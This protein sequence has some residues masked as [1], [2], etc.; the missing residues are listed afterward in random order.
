MSEECGVKRPRYDGSVL[1][2]DLLVG[3]KSDDK[4]H[5]EWVAEGK[6][7][8]EKSIKKGKVSYGEIRVVA[9]KSVHVTANIYTGEIF[10][11]LKNTRPSFKDGPKKGQ[12][13]LRLTLGEFQALQQN[14]KWVE[15]FTL[16][17]I[18]T[19]VCFFSHPTSQA[20]VFLFRFSIF[21]EFLKGG[22]R[23]LGARR[24]VPRSHPG[25]LRLLGL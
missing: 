13:T 15:A 20:S 14:M 21:S 6:E 9:W 22:Q 16:K 5:V 23:T 24:H 8:Y 10:I 11:D 12:F 4:D 2:K 3:L 18:T 7:Y 19:E 17:V 25:T 1:A